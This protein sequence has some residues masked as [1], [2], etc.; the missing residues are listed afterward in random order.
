MRSSLL[1]ADGI[2]YNTLIRER[3]YFKETLA[4]AISRFGDG[5]DTVAFSWLAYELTGSTLLVATLFAVNG[6]PN[7]IFGMISGVLCKYI[8]DKKIMYICDIGRGICVTLIAFLLYTKTIQIWHLYFIT[9]LNSSFESFRNPAS[10]NIIPKILKKDY[11]EKGLALRTSISKVLELGGLAIAPLLITLIGVSGALLIDSITFF[12]CGIII[13]SIKLNSQSEKA[14]YIGMKT[15]LIDLKEGFNYVKNNKII[16][17]ICVFTCIVNGLFVP[18][19]TFQAPYVTEVLKRG[20]EAISILN[21]GV[22]IGM[23]VGPILTPHLKTR[24]AGRIIFIGSGVIIGLGIF[25]L[26]LLDKVPENLV[27]VLLFINMF[28]VGLGAVMINLIIQV[29][30]FKRVESSYL[31]RVS[32][33]ISALA[34]CIIPIVSC[35]VGITSKWVAIKTLFITFGIVIVVIFSLQ[36]LNK[37]VKEFQ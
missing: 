20:S 19:N 27:G 14:E 22:I 15:Y 33:I 32:S 9:F 18:I 5:I 28:M 17:N 10:T 11:L 21:I 13:M 36:V 29:E 12:I 16:L 37:Y 1:T 25:I 30:I 26:G 31:S 34:L 2:G 24:F 4:A 3:N 6:L 7:L 8:S 23:V 35:I